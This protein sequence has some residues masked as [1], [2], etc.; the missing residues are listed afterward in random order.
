MSAP[1]HIL[2]YS[3]ETAGYTRTNCIFHVCPELISLENGPKLLVSSIVLSP[4]FLRAEMD[5]LK[6]A[7]ETKGAEKVHTG[8]QTAEA[9]NE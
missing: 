5:R 4:A 3:A 7:F 9:V 1:A 6:G 8:F 2:I